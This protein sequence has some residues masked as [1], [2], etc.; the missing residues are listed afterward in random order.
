MQNTGSVIHGVSPITEHD[1]YLFKQGNHFRLY[2]K[3][4]AR[5]TN[6]D[7]REG[8][9]FA[10]WA[11]NAQGVSITGDFNDWSPISH[12]MKVRQDESG[13]WEGFVPGLGHLL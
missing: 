10:V 13:I 4:G 2:E 11:P 5:S 1:V 3:L 12:P 9:F 7:G 6:V 8:T